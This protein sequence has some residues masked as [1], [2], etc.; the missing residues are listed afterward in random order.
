[1]ESSSALSNLLL[2]ELGIPEF[3]HLGQTYP[4]GVVLSLLMPPIP[5]TSENLV[6]ALLKFTFSAFGGYI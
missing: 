1:M 6:E 4:Y 3:K 5:C 2:R